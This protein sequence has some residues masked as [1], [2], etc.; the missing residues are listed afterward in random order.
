MATSASLVNTMYSGGQYHGVDEYTDRYSIAYTI[1]TSRAGDII[2]YAAQSLTMGPLY[3]TDS[4]YSSGSHGTSYYANFEHQYCYA[5][6]CNIFY[7]MT[8]DHLSSYYVLL[9]KGTKSEIMNNGFG[10][11]QIITSGSFS[12]NYDPDTATLTAPISADYFQSSP[13]H[14][15]K[16]NTYKGIYC[17]VR[18][19]YTVTI[20]GESYCVISVTRLFYNDYLAQNVQWIAMPYVC[21][22]F[23]SVYVIYAGMEIYGSVQLN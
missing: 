8:V 18:P 23:S 15:K 20:G 3:I 14:V 17:D 6:R 7:H 21:H 13:D 2:D 4:N 1:S 22:E 16:I 12:A 5:L 9:V 19:L 11:T 10:F